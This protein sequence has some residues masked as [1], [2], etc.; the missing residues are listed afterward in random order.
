MS[1]Y[2]AIELN[3]MLLPEDRAEQRKSLVNKSKVKTNE[4]VIANNTINQVEI[5]FDAPTDLD[6]AFYVSGLR[7]PQKQ[8]TSLSFDIDSQKNIVNEMKLST[9][10]GLQ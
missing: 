1:G 9:A 10:D 3:R 4:V 8:I 5:K 7:L 6:E 2:L